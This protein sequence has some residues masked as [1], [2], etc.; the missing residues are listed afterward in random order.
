MPSIEIVCV[1]QEQP[2]KLRRLSFAV[3]SEAGLKSHRGEDALFSA[4]FAQTEGCMYH[5]GN[6]ILRDP[7]EPPYYFYFAW[8][9][10]SPT[11]QH[12]KIVE[13]APRFVPGLRH[14]LRTLLKASPV[15]RLLFTTDWQF[16]PKR[17]YRS[18][19]LT[20]DKLWRLHDQRKLRMNALYPVVA[21]P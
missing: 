8:E 21:N 5:L 3:E 14:L 6:P 16:G 1:G 4:D 10:L 15:G 11:S 13:F 9:L 12:S 18:P 19:D 20:L 17:I 2:L 7:V